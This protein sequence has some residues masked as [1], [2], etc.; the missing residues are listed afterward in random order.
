MRGAWYGSRHRGELA[1][2]VPAHAT[3]LAATMI[4]GAWVIGRAA[5]PIVTPGT[6]RQLRELD[7]GS[8]DD[9]R[10]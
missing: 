2:A 10:A 6:M 3:F 5:D 8:E 7:N 1:A 9:G 4:A